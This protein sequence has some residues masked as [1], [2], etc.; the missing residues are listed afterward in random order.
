MRQPSQATSFSVL[1]PVGL[2]QPYRALTSRQG[3]P[4]R[5]ATPGGRC[6]FALSARVGLKNALS[7][8]ALMRTPWLQF[9]PN[10]TRIWFA[11]G[12]SN[13]ADTTFYGHRD[14]RGLSWR[15]HHRAASAAGTSRPWR[16]RDCW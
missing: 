9:D 2:T 15:P 4:P 7:G 16:R 3:L 1:T 13:P 11:M 8:A 6:K 10:V 12:G 14:D 5:L